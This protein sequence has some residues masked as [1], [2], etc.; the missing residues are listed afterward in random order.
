MGNRFSILLVEDNP[1]D[2][3]RM[4]DMIIELESDLF[5][6]IIVHLTHA[7]CVKEA[8]QHAD[9]MFHAIL[10]DL[11]LPDSK[12]IHTVMRIMDKFKTTPVIVL[13]SITDAELG[14]AAVK[15]NA[16]DYLVKN[17]ITSA[18]L[19]RSI[20]YSIERLK[21]VREK[22]KLIADLQDAM[23]Q[24]QTLSGMLPI[25]ANCKSIRNDKGYWERLESY[26]AKH[27]KAE[28]THGICPEC[29]KKLYPEYTVD[30]SH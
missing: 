29:M 21:I 16:Q 30:D 5:H 8:V 23:A 24:I 28:F 25:C 3:R 2:V 6:P 26:I 11:T 4:Q 12:G 19:L 15:C 17:E 18:L 10:L 27:S 13:T 20:Q 22:E 1:D 14:L 7:S 9:G